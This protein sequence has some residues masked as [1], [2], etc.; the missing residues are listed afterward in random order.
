MLATSASPGICLWRPFVPSTVWLLL[1]NIHL[2]APPS[3]TPHSQAATVAVAAT[4]TA[5]PA[6]PYHMATPMMAVTPSSFTWSGVTFH[7]RSTS[8]CFPLSS[9]PCYIQKVRGITHSESVSKG[10]LASK[11]LRPS[12]RPSS[13][14]RL[15]I[16]NFPS[17]F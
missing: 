7:R 4:A 1:H 9:R 2:V 11:P 14:A 6:L 17:T 13:Y 12:L 3:M 15:S 8:L 10:N 16:I 5:A